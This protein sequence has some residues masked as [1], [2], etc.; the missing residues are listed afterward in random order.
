MFF[1]ALTQFVFVMSAI[2]VTSVECKTGFGGTTC[3]SLLITISLSVMAGR[4]WVAHSGVSGI[5]LRVSVRADRDQCS[6]LEY[7]VCVCVCV[8]VCICA[9]AYVRLHVC[10]CMC[11]HKNVSC[12]L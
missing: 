2:S 1:H 10:V 7:C 9:G 12:N 11:V 5:K 6:C 8:Y 4:V 3:G